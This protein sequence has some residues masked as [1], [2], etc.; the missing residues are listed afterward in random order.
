DQKR[1][2][3]TQSYSSATEDAWRE[4]FVREWGIDYVFVGPFERALGTA[5][6]SDKRY[7]RLEYDVGGY[8][9]YRVMTE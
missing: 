9:V 8:Q 3:V 2:W 7:L 4:A 5:D 6:L 1:L